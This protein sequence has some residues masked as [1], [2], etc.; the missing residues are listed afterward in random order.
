MMLLVRL[1]YLY[2]TL[3]LTS[4]RGIGFE[5]VPMLPVIS[6]GHHWSSEPE[7][8]NTLKRLLSRC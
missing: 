6:S 5:E 8:A 1:W 7:L 4:Y 3:Q 2:I